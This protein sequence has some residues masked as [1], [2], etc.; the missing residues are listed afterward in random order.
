[1]NRVVEEIAGELEL[2]AGEA[3]ERLPQ[4][5]ATGGRPASGHPGRI[6]A[7]PVRH[8]RA[9]EGLIDKSTIATVASSTQRAHRPS[10]WTDRGNLRPGWDP[11]R[12]PRWSRQL[13]RDGAAWRSGASCLP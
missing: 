12:L 8:E 13:A 11:D 3:G 5:N 4:V 9:P 7:R 1:V 2:S 6:T 10:Q